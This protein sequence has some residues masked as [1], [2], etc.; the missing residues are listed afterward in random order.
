[1]SE[2]IIKVLDYIC[3]QLGVVVDWSAENV[4]PQV[5]DILNR[6]R[7]YKIAISVLL[8][9]FF[10]IILIVSGICLKKCFKG[11]AAKT[12]SI[13]CEKR[14]DDYRVTELAETTFTVGLTMIIAAVI[15]IGVNINF[16]LK[17]LVVPEIQYL[18]ML[19]GYM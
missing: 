4:M 7:V 19:Q 3:A 10:I 13:W 17:W 18:A 14:Y 15:V 5:M 6:Y 8:I 2:E 11:V 12:E 1:M 16:L 9:L